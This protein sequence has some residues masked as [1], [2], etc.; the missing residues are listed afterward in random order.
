MMKLLLVDIILFL[1]TFLFSPSILQQVQGQQVCAQ[2]FMDL[3]L[4]TYR[5]ERL[6]V[7]EQGNDMNNELRILQEYQ[8][9]CSS[10]SITSLMLGIDVRRVTNSRDL[11]PSVRV[12]RRNSN[13][14]NRYN[15]VTGSERTIY[16]STSNVS[17]SGVFEYPLNPP[18]PVMSG[19]LLAVSQP[20]QR[21][22]VVRVYYID[23]ISFR[24]NSEMLNDN[25]IDLRN[26]LTTN[27]LILVYPVTDGYCVNSTNLITSSVIKQN[28]LMIHESKLPNQDRQF[29]YPEIVLSCNGTITKWIFGGI[30]NGN[31][32]EPELQIWRQQGTNNYNKI[33]SSLVNA[34][35][36]IGTNLYQFVPQ[37]PLQFVEG[38]IFGVHIPRDQVYLYEQKE[39][40][41]INLRVDGSAA[42]P[43]STITDALHT[44][45]ANDFPLVTVEIST[46]TTSITITT[47]MVSS[48]VSSFTANTMSTTASSKTLST[49][50]IT[51][52]SN[53]VIIHSSY[54]SSLTN[55]S[56]VFPTLPEA[57]SNPTGGIV[58]AVL[59]ILI[60]VLVS[61]VFTSVIGYYIAMKRKRQQIKTSVNIAYS[62]N[63]VDVYHA[64]VV[65]KDH[66]LVLKN[67]LY[68]SMASSSPPPDTNRSIGY[69]SFIL[70]FFLKSEDASSVGFVLTSLDFKPRSGGA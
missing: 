40:G 46:S 60:A 21:D 33:G 62:A 26:S 59:V 64:Q 57:A 42:N 20:E 38:D 29:L 3:S 28:A 24:S 48:S 31:Q 39:S 55:S 66:D 67:E 44:E 23:G 70:L 11:F 34:N 49:S 37:T 27:Q 35:T 9:N 30:G 18:I 7:M 4:V 56:F 63:S 12:F 10:T 65:N 6:Q 43:L 47:S 41:P 17:T 2:R 51:Y 22:S 15:A 5:A 54:M 8:F 1:S 53:V 13:N 25:T 58:A 52:T 19:D 32:A 45:G 61:V 14:P 69:L 36:M 50:S 68:S 16:Y